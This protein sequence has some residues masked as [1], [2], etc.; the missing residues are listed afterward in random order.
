MRCLNI[1]NESAIVD[2]VHKIIKRCAGNIFITHKLS[3]VG[4]IGIEPM[5]KRLRASCSTS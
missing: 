2:D 4:R 3:M 5:T 1:K